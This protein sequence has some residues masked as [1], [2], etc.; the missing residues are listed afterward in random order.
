MAVEFRDGNLTAAGVTLPAAL[1]PYG[2]VKLFDAVKALTRGQLDAVALELGVETH[3]GLSDGDLVL[4]VGSELQHA[5]FVNMNPK[6]IPANVENNHGARR[7]AH[8]DLVVTLKK[9]GPTVAKKRKAG[10]P[11]RAAAKPLQYK[12]YTSKVE[13]DKDVKKYLDPQN[14]SKRHDGIIIQVLAGAKSGERMSLEQVTAS[15]KATGRYTTGDELA[16]SVRWHLAKLEKEGLVS[17]T[18]A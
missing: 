10:R 8:A 15:V 16:K 1:A 12:L 7:R 14:E 11:A 6:E 5:W 3:P 4:T 17:A 18:E 9:G 13:E 2:Q